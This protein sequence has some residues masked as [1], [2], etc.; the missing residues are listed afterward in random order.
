[1]TQTEYEQK[2]QECWENFKFALRAPN[3]DRKTF[4]YIFDRAYA[5]GRD[6]ESITQEEIEKAADEAI[7]KEYLCER[8]AWK[9]NCDHCGG[10]NTA[11]DCCE[12]PADSYEDGFKAGANFALGKQEKDADTVIQG[13]VC[14]DKDG[15]L[16]I[17]RE[18]EKSEIY[19]IDEGYWRATKVN[20]KGDK[21]ISFVGNG[22]K[23]LG[24]P[25]NECFP[26]LTWSDGPQECEIIIKRKKK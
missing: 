16:F 12:C 15:G 25:L 17:F 24:Y 20:V 6:A 18:N 13:W 4:D 11:F 9:D 7:R 26:D 22:G 8:C 1:M 19:L 5:L 10:S 3:T 21:L 14:R 2:K 23:R